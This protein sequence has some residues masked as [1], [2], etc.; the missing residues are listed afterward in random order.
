M[1]IQFSQYY[2]FP[3]CVPRSVV[4][5]Q[6]TIICGF[7][8]GLNILVHWSICLFAIYSFATYFEIKTVMLTA[9]FLL[10]EITL[11]VQGFFLL[12]YAFYIFPISEKNAIR[13]LIRFTFNM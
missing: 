3:L 11:A 9:L 12:P 6:L 13:I 4:E 7:I 10:F 5:E 8:S 1:D 2:L